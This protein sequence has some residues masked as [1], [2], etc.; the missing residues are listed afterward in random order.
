MFINIKLLAIVLL[1]AGGLASCSNELDICWDGL[2]GTQWKLAFINDISGEHFKKLILEPHDCDTCFT[3]TFDA[4]KRWYISGVS[5][6]N[7]FSIHMRSGEQIDMEV[8][9]TDNM[10]EPY[11]GNLFSSLI[12][13]VN[14]VNGINTDVENILALVS[15]TD[16]DKSVTHSLF[17]KRINH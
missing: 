16:P 3:L 1:L 7:T 11:D 9:M 6:L 13:F 4:E 14:A 15:N 5:I 17:F 12:R 10:D 2:K 8:F